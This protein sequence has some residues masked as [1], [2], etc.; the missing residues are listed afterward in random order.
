MEYVHHNDV[1]MNSRASQ[2]T[3]V[4]IVSST[5]CSGADQRKHQSSAS[6]AYVRGIHRWPVDSLHKGPVTQKCFHLMTSS[7]KS[8]EASEKCYTE[9]CRLN[10][11]QNNT[12]PPPACSPKKQKTK[13]KQNNNKNTLN[14]IYININF[15]E[16]ILNDWWKG[17]Q[18]INGNIGMSIWINA[19]F[20]GFF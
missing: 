13:Q 17:R 11:Y 4:S 15:Q 16:Y 12:P 19:D 14:L 18:Q 20:L 8:R 10:R 5:V 1:M 7:W 6:L 2:I 3:G 9:I